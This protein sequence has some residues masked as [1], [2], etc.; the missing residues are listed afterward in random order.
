MRGDEVLK[1]VQTLPE[2]GGDR[3]L[4]DGSVRLRHQAT[5]ARELANLRR[6]AAGSRIGHHVDRVE[7]LLFHSV[8]VPVHDRL[9]PEL[10]H[11]RLGDLLVGIRPDVHNLVVALSLGHQTRGILVLDFLHRLFRRAENRLLLA[12]HRHVLDPDRDPGAGRVAES[13]VHELV[14]EHDR[15]LQPHLAVAGVDQR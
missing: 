12:R 5:H 9:G 2:I 3:R 11:H 14:G 13:G 15:L 6:G 8:A 7:R 4:D 1:Y 10:L